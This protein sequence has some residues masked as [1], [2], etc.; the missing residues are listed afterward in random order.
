MAPPGPSIAA[1]QVLR[2]EIHACSSLHS[3]CNPKYGRVVALHFVS[4][5]VSSPLIFISASGISFAG[6]GCEDGDTLAALR[7]GPSVDIP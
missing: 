3:H 7:G 5:L 6:D 2:P 1:I 4:C